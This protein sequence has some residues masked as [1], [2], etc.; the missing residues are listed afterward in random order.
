MDMERIKYRFKFIRPL[1]IPLVLYLALLPLIPGLFLTFGVVGITSKIDE[2][3]R[4]IMLEAV[5]FSF[6]FTLILLFTFAL[7][8]LVGVP[9]PSPVI[10]VTI[11]CFLVVIGKLRGNWKYR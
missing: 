7:L 2:M 3:E 11:M 1:L 9:D 6:V 5:S 10:I 4:R 8:G